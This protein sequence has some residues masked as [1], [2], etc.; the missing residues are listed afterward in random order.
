[1][2]NVLDAL[3]V[4]P[5]EE[6]GVRLR[7]SVVRP[8]AW[9]H[10]VFVPAV[11]GLAHAAWRSPHTGW[12]ALAALAAA[13]F[14]A[15]SCWAVVRTPE[16]VE[17][18]ADGTIVVSA[19]CGRWTFPG[20]TIRRLEVLAVYPWYGPPF[21]RAR[22]VVVSDVAGAARRPGLPRT[23]SWRSPDGRPPTRLAASFRTSGAAQTDDLLARFATV[24]PDAEV[25]DVGRGAFPDDGRVWWSLGSMREF[26]RWWPTGW[27][28]LPPWYYVAYSGVL[29]GLVFGYQS[30]VAKGAGGRPFGETLGAL[31][32]AG[33]RQAATAA[34]ALAAS[35]TDPCERDESLWGDDPNVRTVSVTYEAQLPSAAAAK[36]LDTRV[37]ATRSVT[38]FA[39]VWQSSVRTDH[40]VEM[41]LYLLCVRD[42]PGG[43]DEAVAQLDAVGR[44]WAGALIDAARTDT[45]P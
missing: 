27:S 15:R 32:A 36:A 8:F 25:H 11:A 1:M 12:F 3:H 34:P 26:A 39:T 16:I 22:L 18:R 6:G 5:A 20:L 21:P 33:P 19:I 7:V 42:P 30:V 4:L 23:L 38:P 10:L 2:A 24:A 45:A 37:D 35:S 40:V 29:F 43:W 17:W 14:G 44:P 41:T 9:L 28:L 13:V 31:S